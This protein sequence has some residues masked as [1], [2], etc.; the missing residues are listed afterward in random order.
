MLVKLA[1]IL[2][3]LFSKQG[4]GVGREEYFSAKY[5]VFCLNDLC[6]TFN[7]IEKKG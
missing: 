6:L 2:K 7:T 4:S 5:R 1:N 3:Q